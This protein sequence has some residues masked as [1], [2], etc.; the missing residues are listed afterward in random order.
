[1]S[2][3]ILDAMGVVF[4]QEDDLKEV[5]MPYLEKQAVTFGEGSLKQ[6]IESAY[7]RLTL[8]EINSEQFFH[9]LNIT[10]PDLNFLLPV[11]LDPAFPGFVDKI[12]KSHRIAVLSNDSQQ[13]ANFRNSQLGLSTLIDY[14]VT[15]SLLGAR[16]PDRKAYEKTCWLLGAKPQDCICVDNLESNLRP[17]RELGMRVILFRRDGKINSAYP[18]AR[19]FPEL[20]QMVDEWR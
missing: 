18:L 2:C 8:G 15:S 1:M 16:K 10:R 6:V 12:R 20:E 3:L 9:F 5:F 7:L 19:S 14:Y 4:L 13:W 11:T 17:A